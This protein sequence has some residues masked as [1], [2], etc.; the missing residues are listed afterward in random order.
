MDSTTRHL[1]ALHR[2]GL[3]RGATA[4]AALAVVQPGAR[5]QAVT[6]G[7][8][9]LGVASGDPL[10]DGLVLWT[11]LATAPLE[12]G[13]GIGLAGI[14]V[15][16]E[17]AEDA[18]F[19]RVVQS[20]AAEARAEA[21][22]SVHVEV[23]GLK[24]GR[25]YWYR[26]T[27]QG[28]RSA[29]GRSRT[30]PAAGSAQPVRFVNAGCQMYEHGH[31]TA[32]RHIAAEELDFVFHY[33]DYIYEYAEVPPGE[34]RWG[35]EVRRHVGGE[36]VLL[37]EYR[38]RYAQYHAD[39]DL[40]A[41]HAAHPFI[42]S[43]DDHEV[44]NNWAGDHSATQGFDAAFLLR[45]AAAFQAW[46]ENMPVRRALRPQGP[47][48]VLHRRFGFG[49]VLDL[50]VLDTRQYRDPQPCND[51]FRAPCEAVAR[52]GAQMLGAAQEQWLLD[53]VARSRAAWQVLGQQVMMLQRRRGSTLNMDAWDGAPAA[54]ARLLSGLAERRA[55]AVVLTGDVHSAWAGE[56]RLNPDDLA[57]AAVATEFVGTSITSGGDGSDGGADSILAQNPHVRFFNNR[58]GYTLHEATAG[59]M[60][61][62]FR[63]LDFVSAPG[64][65]LRDRGRFLVE[66][67]RAALLA[68]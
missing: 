25:H 64:A 38:R 4:L 52:P 68:G 1:A 31:F 42:A 28:Q 7:L 23:T 45:R 10:P 13:G 32:W 48:M 55:N 19:R 6:G 16:W 44:Q 8:F 59:R 2:R 46:F 61:A 35:R 34:R 40:Q 60:Q 21:G 67:G 65:A 26:F 22:H 33:G 54:R 57:S 56:L 27:A 66:A 63:G 58:R 30:A 5:A 29:I 18:G 20:G 24:P 39:P 9:S 43:F 62:V 37:A 12:P 3:L 14:P 50:H 53:G 51:G 41:A 15:G 49:G 36:T 17:L 47:A 11:R